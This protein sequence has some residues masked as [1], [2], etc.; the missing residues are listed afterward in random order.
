MLWTEEL[1]QQQGGLPLLCRGSGCQ[2]WFDG[3]QCLCYS[4]DGER[5]FW[6]RAGQ[7]Q[8]VKK[9]KM[10]KSLRGMRQG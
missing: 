6:E 4:E 5:P 9:N 2:L 1:G 3:S 7:Q 10:A 8:S